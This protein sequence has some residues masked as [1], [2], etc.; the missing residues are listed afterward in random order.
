MKRTF[1]EHES[2]TTVTL[3]GFWSFVKDPEGVGEQE[4]WNTYF[5]DC[6]ETMAVSGCWDTKPQ[7][8][9]CRGVAWY[10]RELHV[11]QRAHVLLTF[12]GVSGIA[13]VYLDGVKVCQH[14]GSYTPFEGL[15]RSLAPGRHPLVVKVDNMPSSEIRNNLRN[16]EGEI[17]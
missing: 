7:H 16:K 6:V 15:K 5:P 17:L 3:D 1:T 9:D 10:R 4:R 13:E 14:N 12:E 11:K 2:R 8:F